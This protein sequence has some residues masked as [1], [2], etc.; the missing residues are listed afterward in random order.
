MERKWEHKPEGPGDRDLVFVDWK[1]DGKWWKPSGLWGLKE[2]GIKPIFYTRTYGEAL[3]GFNRTVQLWSS[4]NTSAPGIF[5][6]SAK[7]T[8]SQKTCYREHLGLSMCLSNNKNHETEGML[9]QLAQSPKTM[10]NPRLRN[11]NGQNNSLCPLW[12]SHYR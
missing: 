4:G 6:T 12:F 11:D 9:E 3:R 5:R 8:F 7:S 2:T 1:N 10:T